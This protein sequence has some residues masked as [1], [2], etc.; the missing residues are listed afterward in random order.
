MPPI[1]SLSINDEPIWSSKTGRTASGKMTGTIIAHK[2]KLNIVFAPM[3]SE[4]AELVRNAVHSAF[5][6]VTYENINGKLR[7]AK[8]YAGSTNLNLYGYAPKFKNI[9][10]T[11]VSVNLIEQ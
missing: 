8:F 3:S 10:Y 6:N 1:K 9:K 2:A 4:Q 5:F 7:T 11:D